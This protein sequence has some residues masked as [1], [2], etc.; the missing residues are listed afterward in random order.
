MIKDWNALVDDT[1][2]D[3][4][5]GTNDQGEGDGIPTAGIR[6]SDGSLDPFASRRT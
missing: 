2:I 1:G 3:G 6:L 5:A 4:V